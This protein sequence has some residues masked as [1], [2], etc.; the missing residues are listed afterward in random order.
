MPQNDELILWTDALKYFRTQIQT[1][2]PHNFLVC[3]TRIP[4]P[5]FNKQNNPLSLRKAS[6]T[7][8]LKEEVG[9]SLLPFCCRTCCARKRTQDIRQIKLLRFSR[10][11]RAEIIVAAGGV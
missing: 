3:M 8:Y 9:M 5:H 7:T 4:Y 2:F 11:D 10:L 6:N 1:P